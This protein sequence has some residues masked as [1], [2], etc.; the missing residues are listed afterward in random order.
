MHLPSERVYKEMRSEEV[1]TWIV[2]ANG[3]KETA[4]LIKAPTNTLKAIVSGVQISMVYAFQGNYLCSAI[5]IYD[6]PDAPLLL[7]N[8][9][10][11][12]EE[13]GAIRKVAAT[14]Q[15]PIFLFNEL[16]VCVAWSDGLISNEDKAK[17][18]KFL[19]V[20]PSP[21]SGE[22]TAAANK[23]LDNFCSITDNMTRI[24]TSDAM[25]AIETPIKH[26][27]WVSSI[28]SFA[29]IN[30]LQTIVLD[31]K[32]EG[33]VLEK[34]T[35]ASLESVFP[36][37]L[38][39]SPQVKVGKKQRELIDVVAFHQYGSFF[40]EAK[41]LSVFSAGLNRT[42]ER[43][44]L[45]VQKQA[46]KAIG[47]LVGASKTAKKGIEV[48]DAKGSRIPLVLGKPLHCIV[49]LSE[50]IHEGD[51]TEVENSICKAAIE[52][53]DYFHV[54]DLREL[55]MI[56]K[57]SSGQA[58]TLDFNLMQRFER[59]IKAGTIHMRSRP[60]PKQYSCS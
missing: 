44:V 24:V 16:D 60:A 48:F 33:G 46:I 19:S 7:C 10:R 45:G 13:H 30:D 2:P 35:W 6:V 23:A 8:I 27:S 40:I 11:N 28:V 39:R 21:Y 5:R 20:Y 43:R 51:W 32:D 52:T 53:G 54:F 34:A 12:D 18:G 49:L 14:G 31:D 42:R 17:L 56:L 36:F 59:F 15:T 37:T 3:G 25:P 9:Q 26:G 58:H 38:H 22:Y 57:C 50:L 1:G 41:D 55:V 29:G 4:L 47:Q